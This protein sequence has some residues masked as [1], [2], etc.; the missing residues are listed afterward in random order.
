MCAGGVGSASHEG[1]GLQAGNSRNGILRPKAPDV[2]SRTDSSKV[3]GE[4]STQAGPPGSGWKKRAIWELWPEA[5]VLRE[6]GELCVC[7]GCILFFLMKNIKHK[8]GKG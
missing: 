7:W 4:V 3:S 1:G 6:R 8:G 5:Q 2:Q